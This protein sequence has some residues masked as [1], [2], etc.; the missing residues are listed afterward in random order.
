M[1][2]RTIVVFSMVMML[3]IGGYWL[4][5]VTPTEE[6]EEVTFPSSKPVVLM[7]VDSLMDEPLQ[8]ILDTEELPALEF[9]INEGEYIPDLISSYPTMSVS[10]DS[11]LLTGHYPDQHK[12]PG[13]IWMNQK[14]NRVV[15]YGTGISE[16]LATGFRQVTTDNLFHINQNH[17]SPDTTTIFEELQQNGQST[18]S[19]NGII[20]RG[21]QNH[22]LNTPRI[23]SLLNLLPKELS[24]K[25]PEILSLGALH[26]I[27]ND[28][29]RYSHPWSRFGINDEFT[30][31]ELTHLIKEKQLPQFTLAYLPTLDQSVHAD[32]PE[33][34]EGIHEVDQHLQTILS[35]FP[36]WEEAL[37]EVTWVIIGDSGQ[38]KVLENEKDALIPLH[39]LLTNYD[40]ADS[41][42]PIQDEHDMVLAVNQRMAYIYLMNDEI[43]Y[44]EV[45]TKLNKDSRIDFLSWHQDGE[46]IVVNGDSKDALEFKPGTEFTDQFDQ[47]WNVSGDSTVL[48]M[49]V[50]NDTIHFGQYPDALSRLHGAL[51]SHE[52]RIL[53]VDAKP[54]YEFVGDH[55]P[56]HL[57]GGNHGSL[58]EQDSLT[59]MIIAGTESK[60]EYHRIV[61]LKNW[62]LELTK[63]R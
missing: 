29:R 13:L 30:T 60:P 33:A 1:L 45:A 11:T 42:E 54:G 37:E 7:I 12:L 17:L 34:N 3:L 51:H 44:L 43:D 55:S 53:I 61:D 19:I 26:R 46:N 49:N 16:I 48:D 20:Y 5:F 31:N 47:S 27:N 18:A 22:E 50:K 10:I 25:G 9:L 14:E 21:N 6:L 52:G 56:T 38:T 63:T 36:S 23:L 57:D 4:S 58:H 15:N 41:T 40:V 24:V 8:E 28:N 62:I 32:G 2:L 35:S 39:D 59:A